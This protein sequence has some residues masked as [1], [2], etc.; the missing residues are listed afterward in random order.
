ML[1][2]SPSALFDGLPLTAN[3]VSDPL[4]ELAALPE[5]G[6]LARAF[7]GLEDAELR[8]GVLNFVQILADR[9]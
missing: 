6:A 4:F 9:H 2:V 7:C 8:R 3:S 1:G 5:G